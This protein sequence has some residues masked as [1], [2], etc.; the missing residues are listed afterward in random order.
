MKLVRDSIARSLSIKNSHNDST[1]SGA[2]TES[3]RGY[4]SESDDKEDIVVAAKHSGNPEE[5][6]EHEGL[7]TRILGV[8]DNR[9][10]RG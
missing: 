8:Y 3:E 2:D 4:S 9:C 10:R 5:F 6:Q 1:L 7:H